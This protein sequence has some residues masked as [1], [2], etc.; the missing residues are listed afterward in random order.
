MSILY[1]CFTCIDALYHEAKKRGSDTR[2]Q[3]YSDH[4]PHEGTG[5]GAW[6]PWS[7]VV[8]TFGVHVWGMLCAS[9]SVSLVYTRRPGQPVVAFLAFQLVVRCCDSSLPGPQAL[10][11]SSVSFSQRNSGLLGWRCVLTWRADPSK[12][13]WFDTVF[14]LSSP[15]PVSG[16]VPHWLCTDKPN[17]WKH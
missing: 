2:D 17:R 12:Q 14:K 10:R 13:P 11:A 16:T 4:K 9:S 6:A 1:R 8:F 5:T 7:D 15:V 3:S